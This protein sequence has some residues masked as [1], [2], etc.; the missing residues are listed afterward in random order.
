[1]AKEQPKPQGV[2]V[3]VT[4]PDGRVIANAADFDTDRPG[5]FK[6]MEAQAFRA[7]N[8]AR[9]EVIRAY[10]SPMLTDTLDGYAFQTLWDRLRAKGWRE[11]EIPVN[12]PD[13]D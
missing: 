6:L 4:D 2:V 9:R 5:G 10:C 7:R 12:H 8:T 11:T 3:V 13:A 1:M